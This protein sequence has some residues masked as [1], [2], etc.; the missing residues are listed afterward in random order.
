MNIHN[1]IVK[2]AIIINL[3]ILIISLLKKY[4][5]IFFLSLQY[6]IIQ[7]TFKY[8]E[9]IKN[10]GINIFIVRLLCN[11]TLIVPIFIKTYNLL[12]IPQFLNGIYLGILIGIG[13]LIFNFNTF[14]KLL[15]RENT[16][17][18][19]SLQ[20]KYFYL[21]ILIM[22]FALISEEIFFRLYIISE[23]GKEGILISSILFSFTHYLNANS[24]ESFN[25]KNYVQFFIFGMIT[26]I[27]FFLTKNI[28]SCI[29]VHFIYNLPYM[30]VKY[31]RTKINL[32]EFSFDD[33]ED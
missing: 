13:L 6:L 5:H 3:F 16:L 9:S 27:L 30:I 19:F 28:Y 15:S 14:K 22:L 24:N 29:I 25:L 7:M 31:K 8:S 32:E 18:L 21:D 12:Y 20:K 2:Y 10:L 17:L 33:Y 11:M 26:S 23:F 1:K 4:N